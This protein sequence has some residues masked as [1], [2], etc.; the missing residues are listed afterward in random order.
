MLMKATLLHDLQKNSADTFFRNFKSYLMKA[1]DSKFETMENN[2]WNEFIK[3]IRET[4]A[5]D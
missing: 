5:L 3:L 2:I 4:Y 1:S